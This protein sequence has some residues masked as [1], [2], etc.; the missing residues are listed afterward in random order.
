MPDYRATFSYRDVNNGET[1]KSFTG[2]FADNATAQTNLASLLSALQNATDAYIYKYELS[3]ID[4]VAGAAAGTSNV[5][6]RVSATVEL[7]T[8][9]K[10]A[11]LELPSPIDGM[12]TGNS[13]IIA[14][15]QWVA[16]TDEF[17]TGLWTISDG[18][19]I[20]TTV[21]GA[22]VYASSGKTNL[23]S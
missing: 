3:E 20:D 8:L 2:T 6:E 17:A 12:F 15:A 14:N 5:F 9:G 18:E 22:R 19:H 21:R 4:L 11:N 1:T 23:P 13:L 7:D 16:V 10:R